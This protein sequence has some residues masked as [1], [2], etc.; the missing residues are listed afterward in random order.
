M[1]ESEFVTSQ[2]N[3]VANDQARSSSGRAAVFHGV[4]AHDPGLSGHGR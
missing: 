3:V 1:L 4:C 2:G